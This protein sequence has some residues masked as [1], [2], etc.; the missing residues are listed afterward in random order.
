MVE[1]QKEVIKDIREKP[2]V[3]KSWERLA[4][5]SLGVGGLVGQQGVLTSTDPLCAGLCANC[6]ACVFH[7][8]FT[9][10]LYELLTCP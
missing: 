4:N 10:K 1:G 9:V 6:F 2:R 8:I 3:R 5:R 7:V